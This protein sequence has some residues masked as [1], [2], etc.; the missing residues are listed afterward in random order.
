MI[1][2]AWFEDWFNSPYY[3]LLYKN[4]N[5]D[6]A[7]SFIERLVAHLNP[8]ENARILD[9]ACGKG[10]HSKAL[11]DMGFDVTGIDLSE[12]SIE[13][14]NKQCHEKLQFFIH[15]MRLP[16][17]INYY[18]FAFNIFT[19]FGYFKTQREHDNA[20]R[21]ITQSLKAEGIVV[22]DY[23]NVDYVVSQLEPKTTV[24]CDNTRFYIT[25]WQDEKHFYKQIEVQEETSALTQLL[26]T[27]RVA[28]FGLTDFEKMLSQQNTKVIEVFGD[29]NLGDYDK[30]NSPRLIIVG[31]KQG[32]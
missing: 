6:E 2:K 7:Q 10:R 9:V 5:E 32:I 27:E 20:I 22:I 1:Q 15:D 11:A 29:Y 17:R 19:S 16:F 30:K 28:K 13:E 8:T 18:D 25:K 21:T 3:H 24:D 14:A 12:A 26:Y 4:R 31:R 23:L